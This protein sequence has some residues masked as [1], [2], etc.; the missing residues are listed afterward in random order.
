[1]GAGKEISIARLA[2]LIQDAIQYDGELKFDHSKPD[3]TPE[4][5]WISV[6]CNPLGG[7]QKRLVDGIKY[8]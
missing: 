2:E 3:G 1:M 4:S 5:Y 8:S 6:C 7:D